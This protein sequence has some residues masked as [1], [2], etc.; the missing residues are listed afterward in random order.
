MENSDASGPGIIP[1]RI[2]ANHSPWTI[3]FSLIG[4]LFLGSKLISFLRLIFSLFIFPGTP[5]CSSLYLANSPFVAIVLY[6][7]LTIFFTAPEFRTPFQLG[8]RNWC[9]GRHWQRIRRTAFSARLQHSPRLS[10][11]VQTP[12]SCRNPTIQISPAQCYQNTRHRL[13]VCQRRRLCEIEG[14]GGQSRRSNPDQQ[15]WEEP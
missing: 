15:C 14:L 11:R 12:I 6:S 2:Q 5:V 8:R 1:P 10:H 7:M 3:L 13:R 4:F 9:F